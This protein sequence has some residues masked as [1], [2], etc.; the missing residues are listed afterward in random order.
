MF[1]IDLGIGVVQQQP[2]PHQNPFVHSVGTP[3]AKVGGLQPAH[4]HH[5][6]VPVGRVAQ[7]V[8]DNGFVVGQLVSPSGGVWQRALH[9]FRVRRSVDA[10]QPIDVFEVEVVGHFCLIH[11]EG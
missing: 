3:L 6:V 5:G 2:F 9:D 11:V 4:S 8:I 1:F 10:L 7:V